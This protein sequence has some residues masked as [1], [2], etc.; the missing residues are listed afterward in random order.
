MCVLCGREGAVE[1][2]NKKRRPPIPT[3]P[4]PAQECGLVAEA[5][6]I[7]ERAEWRSFADDGGKPGVDMNRVGGP[8]NPLLADGLSTSIADGPGAHS[9]IL[10][11]AHAR[12]A[13]GEERTL[14]DGFRRV[15]RLA[16]DLGLVASVKDRA[17]SLY[18]DVVDSAKGVRGRGA[19]AIAAAVI[20]IACRQ[21]GAPRTFKEI[22][23][24][25]PDAAKRDVSRAYAS[26]V[27]DVGGAAATGGTLVHASDLT[28]RFCSSLGLG[29]SDARAATEAAEAACPRDGVRPGGGAKPWDGRTPLS[30]A[31]AVIYL[32]TRLPKASKAPAAVDV[33][34]VAGVTEAT[35]RAAARDMW[36]DLRSIL[37][38]WW[39]SDTEVVAVVAP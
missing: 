36:P 9:A 4:F 37:P 22:V 30:Q 14:V 13:G 5:H 31:A 16:D 33:A 20:Y 34:G 32:V 24:A 19:A 25:A 8:V 38:A 11:R 29:A 7:D 6:A 35:L 3:H 21:E 27:K 39:A 17:C 23:A 1:E 10:K 18:K 28:R 12:A 26:I 15:S 2:Q